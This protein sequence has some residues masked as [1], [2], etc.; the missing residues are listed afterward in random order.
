MQRTVPVEQ[1][2]HRVAQ[3]FVER[4][5]TACK[6]TVN[7]GSLDAGEVVVI[8]TVESPQAVRVSSKIGRC[9]ACCG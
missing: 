5:V 9:S 2:V 3:P 6:E 1:V 4:L 7:L 8:H